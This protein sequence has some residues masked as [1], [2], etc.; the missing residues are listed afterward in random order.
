MLLAKPRTMKSIT[1]KNRFSIKSIFLVMV[2]MISGFFGQCMMT[3][4]A[5]AMGHQM[6]QDSEMAGCDGVCSVEDTSNKEE[7]ALF[8]T[9]PPEPKLPINNFINEMSVAFFSVNNKRSHRANY[10]SYLPPGTHS[11]GIRLRI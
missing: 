4:N 10:I 5:M 11:E 2:L 6:T 3:V 9:D 7:F 8:K 1:L